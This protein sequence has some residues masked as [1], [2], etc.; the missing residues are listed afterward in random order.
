M[1]D[2]LILFSTHYKYLHKQLEKIHQN[3]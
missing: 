3:N 2:S 1:E